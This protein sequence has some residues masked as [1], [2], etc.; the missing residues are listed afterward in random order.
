MN[1]TLG[2]FEKSTPP[3]TSFQPPNARIGGPE[4]RSDCTTIHA[5]LS[6]VILRIIVPSS[7]DVFTINDESLGLEDKER[8]VACDQVTAESSLSSISLVPVTPR[9]TIRLRK[10]MRAPGVGLERATSAKSR[11]VSLGAHEL[12]DIG[13]TEASIVA[14]GRWPSHSCAGAV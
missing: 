7:G 9:G 6:I 11:L 10:Q 2:G 14:S 1:S 5:T 13:E 3:K 8:V 4:L 12:A